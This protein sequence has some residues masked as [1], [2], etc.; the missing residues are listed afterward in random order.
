MSCLTLERFRITTVSLSVSLSSLMRIRSSD[1]S[2]SCSDSHI[3]TYDKSTLRWVCPKQGVS[4]TGCVPNR[5]CPK[6]GV[7]QR[8]LSWE[9]P[10]GQ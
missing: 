10:Q 2:P 1:T 5:V 8:R 9:A 4:Q 3:D 7:S 6:D